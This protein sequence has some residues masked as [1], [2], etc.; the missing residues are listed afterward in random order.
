MTLE[1][2]EFLYMLCDRLYGS[3]PEFRLVINC[4]EDYLREAK[5]KE[6]P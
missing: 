2:I 5:E 1:T 3:K 6:K 4:Y